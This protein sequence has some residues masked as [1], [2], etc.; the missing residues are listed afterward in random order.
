MHCDIR[1][2]EDSVDSK[3]QTPMVTINT[4]FDSL[5]KGVTA[6]FDALEKRLNARFDAC[7]ATLNARHEVHEKRLNTKFDSLMR[8]IATLRWMVIVL[9]I[10][11]VVLFALIVGSMF[12]LRSSLP[13]FA[14]Y[15]ARIPQAYV[16]CPLQSPP[17]P[18]WTASDP[19]WRIPRK[20]R[21]R[22]HTGEWQHVWQQRH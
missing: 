22:H 6:R 18:D 21:T 1:A 9:I 15:P 3:L 13:P 11:V 8:S 12:F 2:S 16:G 14:T 10:L 17:A 7:E 20:Q 4:R 5:Q 19:D